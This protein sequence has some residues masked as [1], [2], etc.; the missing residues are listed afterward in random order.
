MPMGTSR[1]VRRIACPL[2]ALGLSGWVGACGHSPEQQPAP[3]GYDISRVDRVQN[4]FPP[5]FT[6]TTGLSKTLS[7]DD[8]QRAG[9]HVLTKADL[10]PPDCLPVI[11]PPYADITPGTEAAGV[12]AHGDQGGVHMTAF[13]LP[14][15]VPISPPPGGCDQVQLH[16]PAGLTGTAHRIPAPQIDGVTTTAVKL[17]ENKREGEYV[18]NDA[19]DKSQSEPNYLLTAALDDRT[20]I[21]V[22]GSVDDALNPQQ[23]FSDLLVKATAAVRGR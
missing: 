10:D 12:T 21:V 17:V 13:R 22:R 7:A 11:V 6:V 3:A 8:I 19:T 4:D 5:D 1:L 15:P 20:V 18:F 16:S 9:I 23:F 14:K 2:L